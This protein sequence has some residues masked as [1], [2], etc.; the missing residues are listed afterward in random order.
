MYI[1]VEVPLD[2]VLLHRS[3]RK[4]SSRRLG[5]IP[6]TFFCMQNELIRESYRRHKIKFSSSLI[7]RRL[8]SLSPVERGAFF[9]LC[10]EKVSLQFI[11][12]CVKSFKS[13]RKNAGI[14]HKNHNSNA[15]LWY[16]I[17]FA[18]YYRCRFLAT[19]LNKHLMEFSKLT[20]N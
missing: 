17:E 9:A 16:S 12:D 10:S 11:E 2:S 7:Q 19:T 8:I 18:S 15:S 5:R 6:W 4:Q 14:S 3:T 20:R 13:T 1:F